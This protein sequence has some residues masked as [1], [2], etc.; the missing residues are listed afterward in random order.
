VDYFSNF[1]EI[2]FLMDTKAET[3]IGKLK[4]QFARHGIPDIV[5]SDN[6]PQFACEK[7]K[8]FA[9]EWQFTHVTS[10]PAY[11]QSNG[12]VENAVK[13]LKSLIIKAQ[14]DN[15]DP[16]MAILEF[17]NTPTQAVGVSPAQ[18][19]FSRRTKTF[20][21]TRASLLKPE[22]CDY[23]VLAAKTECYKAKM[24]EN[25]DHKAMLRPLSE[26]VPG[27]TV[28]VQPLKTGDKEW[29]PGVIEGSADDSGRS[30]TVKTPR[31]VL[32][33][34]RRHLR[35]TR[36]PVPKTLRD[37]EELELPRDTP[38]VNLE[39]NDSD[40]G[41]ISVQMES[42]KDPNIS[43]TPAKVITRSGRS[44]RRPARFSET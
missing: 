5:F 28:R 17:R 39:N 29:V 18:R 43:V 4:A 37:N 13:T 42:L 25:Y 38:V 12:K 1:S 24:K 44:V 26:L 36:E 33:R 35:K 16:Y 23:N 14:K 22:V 21:P 34:N 30:Y 10:S 20:L 3:V 11:P 40:S 19:L 9:T 7:F 15:R 27:D 8:D 32:R 2:D 31:S 41:S 6:G